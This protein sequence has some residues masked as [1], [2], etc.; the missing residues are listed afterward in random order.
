MSTVTASNQTNNQAKFDYDISKI[1]IWNNR[2]ISATFN[3]DTGAEADFAPGT[4]VAR[5]AS[6]AKIVV[7]DPT[8]IDGSQIPIGVLKSSITALADAADKV[9]NF[10]YAGDVVEDKLILQGSDTLAT[11][12]TI[13][14][15]T[16][17]TRII[18]DMLTS[19]GINIIE[20]DEQTE[21]DN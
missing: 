13:G 17:N 6:T 18:R 8:A 2:Y 11:V 4:V 20:S 5:I 7:L 21:F 3:N 14:T 15:G 19:V 1:F 10:C 12:V 9:V 16:E